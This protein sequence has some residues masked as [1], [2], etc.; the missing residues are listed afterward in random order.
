MKLIKFK[1][2]LLKKDWTEILE[3]FGLVDHDSRVAHASSL[4]MSKEDIATVRKN[5]KVNIKRQYPQATKQHVEYSES[6]EFLMYGANSTLADGIKKGYAL[7][8]PKENGNRS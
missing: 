8:M 7:V 2:S 6:Y 3:H 1:P 5:T 4:Y